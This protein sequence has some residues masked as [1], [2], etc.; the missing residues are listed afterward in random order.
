MVSTLPHGDLWISR[1]GEL[2][3]SKK[4]WSEIAQAYWDETNFPRTSPIALFWSLLSLLRKGG[5]SLGIPI[6]FCKNTKE[7]MEQFWLM[8]GAMHVNLTPSFTLT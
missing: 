1:I 4:G 3:P 2:N 7:M 6:N 8:L 5:K